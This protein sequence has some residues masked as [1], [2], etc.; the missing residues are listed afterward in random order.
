MIMAPGMVPGP[1]ASAP[2][3]PTPQRV[4]TRAP[5]AAETLPANPLSEFNAN[6]V[7]NF[8]ECTLLESDAEMPG[9]DVVP[10]GPTSADAPLALAFAAVRRTTAY[11]RVRDLASKLPPDV[12]TKLLRFGPYIGV[13]LA[14]LIVGY[15][16][17]HRT[18]AA[19]PVV[20]RAVPV[21]PAP[22]PVAPVAPAVE[23]ETNPAVGNPAPPPAKVAAGKKTTAAEKAAPEERPAEPAARPTVVAGEPGQCTARVIT[24]PK[25]AKVL[26]DGKLIGSSPLEG[27]RVP[28]GAAQV[29]IDRVRWQPVTVEVNMQAG[30]QAVVHQRLH[31][32]H[33]TLDISSTPPGAHIIVNRAA[34]GAAP[35]HL[36][37]WR[38]EQV[39]I[40]ASLKGY[41]PWSKKVYLR[42]ADTKI[43]IELVPKK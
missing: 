36:D 34:V 30:D 17:F 35:R 5:R 28:C 38:Y 22:A 13:A 15:F 16:L 32:P 3:V 39:S 12:Q 18:P 4:E 41:R 25:D 14:S 29:T 10:D 11:V 19:A 40:R 21:A 1:T 43:D 2:R 33:G 37:A 31:R 8:I 42:E 26:W 24:E 20:A 6:E 27:A 7:D 9:S 23:P